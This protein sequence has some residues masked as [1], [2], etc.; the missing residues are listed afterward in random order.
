[1]NETEVAMSANGLAVVVKKVGREVTFTFLE[2]AEEWLNNPQKTKKRK[3]LGELNREWLHE[4]L[5]EFI[6][7][8]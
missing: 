8:I 4:K 6:N 7:L 2:P 3:T 1:M 5:D